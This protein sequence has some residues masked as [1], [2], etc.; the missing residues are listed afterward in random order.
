MTST[1]TIGHFW[2]SKNSHLCLNR[3]VEPH[4]YR[5]RQI[6]NQI[7]TARQATNIIYI[8]SLNRDCVCVFNNNN[9]QFR[10]YTFLLI[11]FLFYTRNIKCIACFRYYAN[12]WMQWN[13]LIEI[14]AIYR[15]TCSVPELIRELWSY[16]FLSAFNK[17]AFELIA[18]YFVY[19]YIYIIHIKYTIS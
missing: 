10:H 6:W 2:V 16:F 18:R 5:G 9:E 17:I 19:I 8:F 7:S 14:A 4:D 1:A 12:E 11:F 3:N 13:K 15:L